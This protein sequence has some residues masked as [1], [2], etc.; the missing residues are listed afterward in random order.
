MVKPLEIVPTVHLEMAAESSIKA[1]D[2]S[3]QIMEVSP[4]ASS[5]I[6]RVEDLPKTFSNTTH[7][8]YPMNEENAENDYDGSSAQHPLDKSRSTETKNED[9]L[10]EWLDKTTTLELN[11]AAIVP[12]EHSYQIDGM[13]VK[14]LPWTENETK[15]ILA[16]LQFLQDE[17][18]LGRGIN[19]VDST[20]VWKET[21]GAI[22]TKIQAAI[23][24]GSLRRDDPALHKLRTTI[25]SIQ[26]VDLAKLATLMQRNKEVGDIVEGRDVLLLCGE[27]GSGKTTTM[28]FLLGTNFEEVETDGFLHLAPKSYMNPAHAKF[29][30]SY[31]QDP[32][33]RAIQAAKVR[34][35][36]RGE[37]A[38]CDVPSYDV[39]IC[40][41]EDISLGMGMVQAIQRA[42]SVR[43]VVVL[44]REGMGN[45]FGNLPETLRI[46]RRLFRNISSKED[47][48][49]FSY[50]FTKYDEKHRLLLHK[51]FLALLRNPPKLGKGEQDMFEAFVEDLA[52]KTDP[53]A[54]LMLPIEDHPAK[55]LA[56]IYRQS[57]AEKADPQ[58][59]CQPFVSDF[60]MRQMQLQM[61]L[62][63]HDFQGQILQE[64][65]PGAI[66]R[67]HQM[68]DSS[69]LFPQMQPFVDQAKDQYLQQVTQIWIL[70]VRSIGKEDYQTALY[71]MEQLNSMA[72]DFPDA[73]ECSSMG[74]ELLSQS[75]TEPIAQG[76]HEKCIRRMLLLS[77]LEDRFPVSSDAIEA[78]LKGL[79]ERIVELI[80]EEKFDETVDLLKL[81]GRAE[82]DIPDAFIVAQHGLH[83]VREVLL[84]L[85]EEENY[86]QSVPLIM[87]LSE[88]A[89]HFAEVNS[90][91]RRIL[92][93][94][95]KRTERAIQLGHYAKGAYLLNHMTALAPNLNDGVELIEQSL[96]SAAQ[97]ACELRM[98]VVNAFEGLM[99]VNDIKKYKQLLQYA[100]G[101]VD[102]LMQSEC[103]RIACS[104]F[105]KT[106]PI[107]ATRKTDDKKPNYLAVLCTPKDCTSDAFVTAQVRHLVE[108]ISAE[109]HTYEQESTSMEYMMEHRKSLLSIILRQRAAHISFQETPGAALAE[110]LYEKIFGK[111]QELI[112]SLLSL[113][114]AS[115]D[116]SMDMKEFEFQAYFLAFLVQG[117]TRQKGEKDGA[118]MQAMEDFDH[119]R[120]TLM[121]RFENEISN[122]MELLGDYSFPDFR[123]N[124]GKT[125]ANFDSYF[126]ETN[127]FDLEAPRQ[128]LLS[129]SGAPRLCKMM[130]TMLSVHSAQESVEALDKSVLELIQKIV[131]Y[132][133]ETYDTLVQGLRMKRISPTVGFRDAA[134]LSQDATMVH[135]QFEAAQSWSLALQEDLQPAWLRLQEIESCL[136]TLISNLQVHSEKLDDIS[137]L[138]FLNTIF[139]SDPDD[140]GCVGACYGRTSK[141]D[142]FLTELPALGPH[143]AGSLLL[144]ASMHDGKVMEKTNHGES[145]LLS[146]MDY[147]K[148]GDDDDDI[149]LPSADV[150]MLQS[151]EA[152]S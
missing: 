151:I 117:F 7:N 2:S 58:E 80:R 98:D 108:C 29:K 17:I 3:D 19:G 150:A 112:E 72:A 71:R 113:S 65:Y 37:V 20:K 8:S 60:S 51:Q 44:S 94:L 135:P 96:D 78:S 4:S 138:G 105:F 128:L 79:K 36:G 83:L 22:K 9:I 42:K 70:V 90:Q 46:V 152:I 101:V 147:E 82:S 139:S 53:A 145:K 45:R 59:L 64:N 125:K 23:D 55:P 21:L 26:L 1:V 133:E 18:P 62:M 74:H 137:L 111:L 57:E 75:V 126:Q 148:R 39:A 81:L 52:E 33:T 118:D 100:T 106:Q 69:Y 127:L 48:K 89:Q 35:A 104:S 131:S 10:K 54:E 121:L 66:E 24:R 136:Q 115:F 67:I 132:F 99:Q 13:D 93:T 40:L 146:G 129:L 15:Q 97:H 30:T 11:L 123:S 84:N 14:Q 91:V 12:P 149:R 134:G 142:L 28:Q 34:V 110:S 143:Q 61:N 77:K 63:M 73:V 92:K 140:G 86:E 87:R 43:P 141:Y 122:T 85:I 56:S 25:S 47:L 38:I 49:P 50:V 68:V 120:V 16:Q 27:T 5:S 124:E 107:A 114:E 130:A 6:I 41:E 31:S 119:R 109:F 76:C 88:L 95:R 32:T 144:I 116:S 102:K 103:M